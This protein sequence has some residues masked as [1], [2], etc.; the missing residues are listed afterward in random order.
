MSKDTKNKLREAIVYN[1]SIPPL[2]FV[3]ITKLV[4][5]STVEVSRI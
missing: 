5:G 2:K 4:L 3:V 1:K